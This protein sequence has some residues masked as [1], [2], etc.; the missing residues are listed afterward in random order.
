M[1]GDVVIVET[2]DETTAAIVQKI[3]GE[4][5]LEIKTRRPKT[6]K[7]IRKANLNDIN[8]ISDHRK[9]AAEAMVICHQEVKKANFP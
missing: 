9:K 1:L 3:V 4:K 7:V 5:E 6:V 2:K 8:V